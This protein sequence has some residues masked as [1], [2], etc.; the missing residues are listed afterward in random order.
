M[1]LI[2][3]TIA[4]FIVRGM[5]FYVGT[6]IAFVFSLPIGV[7]ATAS[8]IIAGVG[9]LISFEYAGKGKWRDY[10]GI[11]SMWIFALLTTA[12]VV[13]AAEHL[14]KLSLLIPSILT[15]LLISAI[16]LRG[17]LRS[18]TIIH[19]HY[20]IISD[21]IKKNLKII[22]ISD[23]HSDLVYGKRHLKKIVDQ[24]IAEQPDMVLVGGDIVNT[25]QATYVAAFNEFQRIKVPMYAVIGNHDVYFGPFTEVISAVFRTAK[26]L[27]L[28]NKSIIQDGIQIVGI[29]DCKLRGKKTLIDTMNACN[30]QRQGLF[31]IFLTHRPIHLSKVRN[32]PI[33]LEL[34]GHTH[35]GQI[36]GVHFI[37]HMVFDYNYGKYTRKDRTAIVSQGLGAGIPFRIGTEGEI[38]ILHLEKKK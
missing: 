6:R 9:V 38:V 37:S 23:I 3:M 35:N 17:F 36:R 2:E 25:P 27:P 15:V 11:I 8:M 31:T 32:Y 12:T 14:F 13:L 5:L 4:F 29:D 33:D 20:T 18:R 26:M 22:F 10:I 1:A 7:W 16:T 21:K 28:R 19:T 30:I 24:I 34:A